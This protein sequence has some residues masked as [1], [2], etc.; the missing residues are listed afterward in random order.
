MPTNTASW[1]FHEVIPV[2]SFLT[3]AV[4]KL[5]EVMEDG[6]PFVIVAGCLI[7]LSFCEIFS[8]T[9]VNAP[10]FALFSHKRLFVILWVGCLFHFY[11]LVLF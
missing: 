5:F 7:I 2:H 3:T 6:S 4:P 1:Q 9:L 11:F 10:E 8:T